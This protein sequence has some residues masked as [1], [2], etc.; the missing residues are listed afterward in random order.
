MSGEPDDL[1]ARLAAIEASTGK[2]KARARPSLVTALL[3]TAAIL[4]VGGLG[5]MLMQPKSEPTMPTAAAE[6]F[7][8][9][10]SVFGEF[11]PTP[12][13]EPAPAPAPAPE[14]PSAAELELRQTLAMLQAELAELRARPVDTGDPAAQAAIAELTAQMTAL[15]AAAA[16]ARA[17]LERQLVERDRELERIAWIWRSRV[18]AHREGARRTHGLPSWNAVA[19]PRPP[20]ARPG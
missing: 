10:G 3:G 20:R 8:T 7:Q 18:W 1:S 5:W 6:E 19:Q 11:P 2:R 15:E 16:E 13:P 14:G 17:A 9:A 4:T 12:A